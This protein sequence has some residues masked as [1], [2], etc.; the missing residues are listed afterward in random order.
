MSGDSK[1]NGNITAVASS[2]PALATVLTADANG[3]LAGEFEL[4]ATMFKSGEKL[5][6]LTDSETDSVANSESVAEKIF[7]VQRLLETRTGK[8]SSTR[9]MESKRENVKEKAVTQ[10]TI[11]RVT[12][13]TNWVN[14]LTQSFIVDQNENPNGVFASSIDIFFS[15]IDDKLPVTLALRPIINGFPSS[16]QI[17]PFSEVTL[18]A[19]EATANSTAPSVATST[20]YTR[21]TFDSPVY[22]YPDEYAVVL[23]SPST[24]YAVHVANLGETVKNTTNTKVSQQPFVASFYQPQNSSVWQPNAEKQMMFRVNRCEFDTGSHVTYFANKA[25]PLSGNTS[26]PKYDVF[27]LSTSDLTF[28]NTAL[29]FAYKGILSANLASVTNET[30]RG[31]QIDSAWTDFSPNRNYTLAAQKGMVASRSTTGQNDYAAN[32]FFLKAT[33]TSNDSKVSPAVDL[34]RMN[35]ITVENLVNRGSIATSDIVIANGGTSY[36]SAPTLTVSGGGGTGAAATATVA[37]NKITGVTVTSSGSG[38]YET[39]AIAI[40]GTGSSLASSTTVDG[41]TTATV[42][43]TSTLTADM[44]VTGTGIPA[45]T[46]IVS[47][48][49]ATTFVMSNAATASGT[50]TL[51]FHGRLTVENELSK[52]GGNA[53]ARY[54]SRRV[55]LEDNFDAQDIKVW[56][57]AYKPKDTDIKVYYRVHNSE[58]PT[59]F[60]DRPYV[61]MTQETDANRISASETDVNE[62]VF[63]SSANNVA[64]TSGSIRY[65]KFK[66]FAIKIVLGSASTSVIPKVKDMKAVAL[67]F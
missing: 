22:L 16:S 20:T 64:Y 4:P 32:N 30:S 39:P 15:A 47:I 35:L 7:R 40:S 60:E 26:G 63:R 57:N 24:S 17:L 1:A 41:S 3:V 42:S 43:S 2:T 49:N 65:D 36:G 11:N 13:S 6:R 56:L 37:G 61:L 14:P 5:L 23:T 21:F 67:D 33:F 29:T 62:Y 50:V 53:K 31:N 38:Y 48:T 45:D 28:S 10:D 46:T 34:S 66:T 44:L 51:Y 12:T 27:K 25:E 55:T 52:S 8:I 58:D 54:I 9:P 19:S 59:S 18:N